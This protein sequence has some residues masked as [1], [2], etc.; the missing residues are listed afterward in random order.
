MML[1][2]AWYYLKKSA[3][4]FDLKA[5]HLTP[6]VFLFTLGMTLLHYY[7]TETMLP[8]PAGFSVWTPPADALTVLPPLLLINFF[9]DLIS[10][11]YLDAVL[12]EIKQEPYFAGGCVRAVLQNFLRLFIVAVLRGLAVLAGLLLIV[13]GLIFALQ[14]L[15]CECVLLDQN[16]TIYGSM[17][18]SRRLT[19]GKKL[20]LFYIIVFCDLAVLLFAFLFLSVFSGGSD[21]VFV[22]CF[23]FLFTLYNLVQKRLTAYLYMDLKYGGGT[24]RTE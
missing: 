1:K 15:F 13:P 18:V 23:L 24:G 10:V 9:K 2:N 19:D 22:Y 11:V 5:K 16:T 17:V 20:Y 3:I 21:A 4:F 14:Y 8:Y 7:L 12:K 6:V